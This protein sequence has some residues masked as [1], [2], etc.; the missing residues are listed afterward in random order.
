VYILI[1]HKKAKSR[2]KILHRRAKNLDLTSKKTLATSM[3]LSHFDYACSSWYC[4]IF[5]DLQT[6]QNKIA[7]FV[8][9]LCPRQHIGATK[10]R[11]MGWLN[12]KS[13]VAQL[14]S[15]LVHSIF[16]KKCP[17]YLWEN[18]NLIDYAYF[19]RYRDYNFVV[20]KSSTIIKKHLILYWNSTLE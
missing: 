19:T 17:N 12:V 1:D 13:R 16:Y 20:P 8:L 15:N 10:F 14:K 5:A 11:K 18:F 3:I 2:L 4:N 9:N 7:R 6:C